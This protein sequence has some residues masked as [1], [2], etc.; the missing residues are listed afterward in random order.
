MQR[1]I[2]IGLN[3]LIALA[4]IILIMQYIWNHHLI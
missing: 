3:I 2:K 4:I 1:D